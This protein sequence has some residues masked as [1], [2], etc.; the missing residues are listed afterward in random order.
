MGEV[1]LAEA[2]NDVALLV[3]LVEE[4]KP[5]L[6]SLVAGSG[7]DV[8][9]L[10]GGG[11]D[12]SVVHLSS[13]GHG[14]R[15]EIL[16]LLKPIAH[17]LHVE[18]QLRHI[19]KAATGMAADEI[20]NELVAQSRLLAYLVKASLSFLKEGE[21]RL[22]HQCQ[23]MV[24]GVFRCHLQAT[25]GVIEHHLLEVFPSPIAIGEKVATNTTADIEV[26]HLGMRIHLTQQGSHGSVVTVEVLA[27][28]GHGTTVA[29]T[30]AAKVG[31]LPFHAPHA[32]G[33]TTEI[34]QH[35]VKIGILSDKV[36]FIK[37]RCLTAASYLFPLVGTDSAE[38]TAAETSAVGIHAPAYHF[39][40]WYRSGRR[41]TCYKFH[42]KSA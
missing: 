28:R 27:E 6:V 42:E 5:T 41:C 34:G 15:S 25:G 12:A 19:L 9:G 24:R 32:G 2:G 16:Y 21:R 23:H 1:M 40:G 39:K 18:C 8:N 22:A 36:H 10:H 31:L 26:F 37:Y 35:T 38:G 20:R 30:A 29:G 17:L 33:G 4:E 14:R 13:K 7:G 3:G 11:V